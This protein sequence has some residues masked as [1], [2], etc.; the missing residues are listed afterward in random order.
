MKNKLNILFATLLVLISTLAFT[1]N[2]D[3]KSNKKQDNDIAIEVQ[4]EQINKEPYLVETKDFKIQDFSLST[5]DLGITCVIFNPYKVKVKV[6]EIVIDVFVEDKLLGTIFDDA[7]IIPVT[8][9][10]NFDLPVKISVKTG[11]TLSKF[12]ST[13][14]KLAT[15]K[16]VRVD[17]KGYV[18]VKALGFI[19]VKVK[20]NQTEYF[21]KSDIL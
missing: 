5:I 2:D 7:E 15:G 19:P 14:W 6:T 10:S 9:Q 17:Y 21:D 3:K 12:S 18:K 1:G 8:K 13:F 20:I 4:D 11:A 16:Q